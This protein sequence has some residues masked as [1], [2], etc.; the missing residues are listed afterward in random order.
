M[1]RQNVNTITA[2]DA[3]RI[4]LDAATAEDMM[5]RIQKETGKQFVGAYYILEKAKI[6]LECVEFI[7]AECEEYLKTEEETE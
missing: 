4:R 6:A 1:R 7:V 2:E 5:Q 3:N